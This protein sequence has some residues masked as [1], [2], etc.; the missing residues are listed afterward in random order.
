M[1]GNGREH[2]RDLDVM[3]LLMSNN[4][5]CR[6]Q[7]DATP[8]WVRTSIYRYDTAPGHKRIIARLPA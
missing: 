4:R 5:C 1:G 8:E 7:S 3:P 6:R 2:G